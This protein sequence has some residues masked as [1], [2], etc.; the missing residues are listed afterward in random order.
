MGAVS[1]AVNVPYTTTGPDRMMAWAAIGC[2]GV[3][4]CL[5]LWLLTGPAPR[6]RRLVLT[7]SRTRI[8]FAAGMTFVWILLLGGSLTLDPP[9]LI[10]GVPALGA[11]GALFPLFVP[12]DATVKD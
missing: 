9:Q 2:A 11:V 4:A 5:G 3:G 1:I 7:R 6:G 8:G 10:S 12:A